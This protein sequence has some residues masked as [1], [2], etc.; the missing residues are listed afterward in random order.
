MDDFAWLLP[1]DQSFAPKKRILAFSK[2]TVGA[3]TPSITRPRLESRGYK[4]FVPK[5]LFL[6]LYH[7]FVPVVRWRAIVGFIKQLIKMS[8]A[9]KPG[10]V[11]DFAYCQ[12]G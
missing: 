8:P 4:Y 2:L 12:S 1:K 9:C 7:R 10:L 3:K 11:N 5:G 6:Y